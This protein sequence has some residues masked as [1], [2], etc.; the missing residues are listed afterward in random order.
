VDKF[1][2]VIGSNFNSY[3]P[4]KN[5]FILSFSSL[6]CNRFPFYLRVTISYIS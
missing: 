1:I 2:R 4:Q 3:L 5:T 6:I